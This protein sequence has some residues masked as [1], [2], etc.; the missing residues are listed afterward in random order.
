MYLQHLFKIRSREVQRP[1]KK[2]KIPLTVRTI[3]IFIN[4]SVNFSLR[5]GNCSIFELDKFFLYKLVGKLALRSVRIAS[6][7]FLAL[8]SLFRFIRLDMFT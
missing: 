5:R 6:F 8:T 7:T 1:R 2:M 4:Y 3:D